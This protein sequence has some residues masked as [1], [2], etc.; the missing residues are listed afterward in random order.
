M[1]V[2]IIIANFIGK[3]TF[4]PPPLSPATSEGTDGCNIAV[5]PQNTPIRI[6]VGAQLQVS[7]DG[8]PASSAALRTWTWASRQAPGPSSCPKKMQHTACRRD[9]R[10]AEEELERG[11]G[12]AAHFASKN[13]AEKDP[14][15]SPKRPLGLMGASNSCA[16]SESRMS[17]SV[18]HK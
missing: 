4:K 18:S 13:F 10:C 14:I 3:T 6:E 17:V 9:E 5:P 11:G 7:I 1:F 8:V 15:A 16:F 12:A 2:F